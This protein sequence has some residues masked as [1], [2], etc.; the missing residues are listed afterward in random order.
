MKVKINYSV[1]EQLNAFMMDVY[2][3]LDPLL[4]PTSFNELLN[5]NSWKT[6]WKCIKKL[7]F[8]P[9]SDFTCYKISTFMFGSSRKNNKI[10]R[11]ELSF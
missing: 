4:D 8:A 1:Q 6:K 11:S 10:D 2:M 9:N 5:V 7:G 3:I